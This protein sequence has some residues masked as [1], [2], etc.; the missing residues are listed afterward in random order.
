MKLVT[1]LNAGS[2]E[3]SARF[4]PTTATLL[5]AEPAAPRRPPGSRP[6]P[7]R[8][9]RRRRSHW[10]Q[11]GAT[12]RHQ[13]RGLPSAPRGAGRGGARRGA[14]RP[15]RRRGP[16]RR[17]GAPNGVGPALPLREGA[18]GGRDGTAPPAR[19]GWAQRVVSRRG[20]RRCFPAGRLARWCRQVGPWGDTGG[21]AERPRNWQRARPGTAACPGP[22][23][24]PPREKE[25]ARPRAVPS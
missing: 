12:R 9:P 21:A 1:W 16:S 19:L 20:R 13:A 8:S 17:R 3:T 23:G 15:M 11:P 25:G 4:S 6:G 24:R 10:D 22:P 5:K 2:K 18:E 7:A 14:P